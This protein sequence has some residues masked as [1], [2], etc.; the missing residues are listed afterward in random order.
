VR[1]LA[2]SVVSGRAIASRRSRE[3]VQTLKANRMPEPA[4]T[5]PS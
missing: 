5:E 1:K 2:V 4:V 3:T